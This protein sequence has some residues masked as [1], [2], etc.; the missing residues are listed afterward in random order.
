MTN[1]TS[2][3][4][5]AVNLEKW[6]ELGRR[7][8]QNALGAEGVCS[9]RALRRMLRGAISHTVRIARNIDVYCQRAPEEL[10]AYFPPAFTWL[11]DN[12]Y[13]LRV[14][15]KTVDRTLMGDYRLPKSKDRVLPFVFRLAEALVGQGSAEI[16][17]EIL[18]SFL[19]GVQT[20]C[21]LTEEEINLFPAML[22][23][24]LCCKVAKTAQELRGV[25]AAYLSPKPDTPF[26]AEMLLWRS[27]AKGLA[28][29]PHLMRYACS[30]EPLHGHMER[31]IRGALTLLREVNNA[32]IQAALRK[33]SAL[34]TVLFQ[35]PAHIYGQM[36]DRSRAYYR[37]LVSRLAR[38]GKIPA[39]EMAQKLLRQAQAENTHIGE[40]ILHA[41]EF[42][43]GRKRSAA[44]YLALDIILPVAVSVLLGV[45]FSNFWMTLFA[46][47]PIYEV[48]RALLLYGFNHRL[49][50]NY[51][52]AMALQEGVPPEGQ[53]LAVIALLADSEKQA[54]SHIRLLEEYYLAN[55]T[56]G[57]HVYYGVLADL[58]DAQSAHVPAD[59]S[60]LRAAREEIAELNH[61]WG[62]RF[63]LIY[64]ERRY[65]AGEMAYMAH[66]RKRGAIGALA[67]WVCGQADPEDMPLF[68]GLEEDLLAKTRYL[69]ALDADT[70]PTPD[71]VRLMVGAM[72]HPLNR[73]TV[74]PDGSRVIKGYGI[75]Q[76]RIALELK[77][78][79]ASLFSRIFAGQGGTDP[80]FTAVG[81]V[82]QNLFDDAV[83][84]GK[85]ILDLQVMHTVL[86]GKLPENRILS[87]DLLEGSFLR[88]GYLTDAELIDGFPS[89]VRSYYKRAG[90]WIRGD[91]QLLPYLM[92]QLRN[93]HGNRYPNPL[94]GP[95]KYK[96][97]DNLRRA[98]TP[99][100]VFLCLA[101]Y[102]IFLSPPAAA[103]AVCGLLSLGVPMLL[104]T[105]ERLRNFSN[106]V[107]SRY[108]STIYAG[109][110]GGMLVLFSRFLLLPYEGF[111]ALRAV[112]KALWR[113]TVSKKKL[114]EWVT[115][116]EAERAK[117][118]GLGGEYL[119]MLSQIVLALA[120]AV[121][122]RNALSC[123][124]G[125]LWLLG[126]IYAWWISQKI[127][128]GNDLT[129]REI[130]VLQTHCRAMWRYF[131]DHMTPQDHFLPPDNVQLEPGGMV[132][133]RTSPTNIGLGVLAVLGARY[134]EEISQQEAL[135]R[136]THIAD[137]LER[138]EKWNGHLYNWYHTETL[139]VLPPFVVS[140][141]DSG[142][143]CACLA[144][145]AKVVDRWEEGKALARRL[146]NLAEEADFS[147]LYDGDANL[148]HIA[149]DKEGK[150]VGGH[151]DM[152]ASEARLTGY[153]AIATG[154]V[155]G[156]HWRYLS[157]TMSETNG[158]GGL[159]SWSGSLFEYL[160]PN[161]LL[162]DE[163][164]SLL[165]ETC[166][167]AIYAQRRYG[168]ARHIP[169]GISESCFYA[170]DPA[171]NYQYK[172]HGVYTI[173]LKNG[174]DG[175]L[176]VS[177]YSTFL[178]LEAEPKAALRNLGRLTELG[179]MGPY[180]L[181][182]SADF[183]RERLPRDAPYRVCRT[184]MAHHVGMSICGAVNAISTAKDGQPFF[185]QAFLAD[186]RCRSYRAL[187]GERMPINAINV[188]R[189]RPKPAPKERDGEKPGYRLT[190]VPDPVAPAY[191]LLANHVYSLAMSATGCGKA[192]CKGRLLYQSDLATDGELPG[193][194]VVFRSGNLLC[195]PT[196]FPKDDGQA[197]KR[198]TFSPGLSCFSA[199]SSVLH[200]AENVWVAQEETAENRSVILRNVSK[201][202][203]TGEVCVY[204]QPILGTEAD[205]ESHPDFDRMLLSAEPTE[206]GA[207]ILR[208]N[209]DGTP[210][211]CLAVVCDGKD[212]KITAS[213]LNSIGRREP[214]WA[215][216]YFCNPE[217][218]SFGEVRDC[219]VRLLIP[220]T[221]PAGKEVTI[222]LAL[223]WGSSRD[224]AVACAGRCL[225]NTGRSEF[226][227]KTAD[228]L[229]LSNR[230]VL[231]GLG[232]LPKLLCRYQSSWQGDPKK[233][234]RRHLWRLGISGDLPIVTLACDRFESDDL[235]AKAIFQ[236]VRIHR[237]LSLCGV[238]YDLV[239]LNG[240]GDRYERPTF[241][242]CHW[243][244][245]V[246]QCTE[247]LGKRG[248]IHLP[249][250]LEEQ[251][252]LFGASCMIQ[253]ERD[254]TVARKWS[255]HRTEQPVR[256]IPVALGSGKMP[257]PR[258]WSQPLCNR[259]FGCT[260]TDFGP[261]HLWYRNARL[262]R[263][264]PWESDPLACTNQGERLYLRYQGSRYSVYPSGDG[265]GGTVA[266]AQGATRW[267]K[268]IGDL[269]VKTVAAVAPDK[270]VR[271]LTVTVEGPAEDCY[272]EWMLEPVLGEGANATVRVSQ[273]QKG[274]LRARN[275]FADNFNP[276][277]VAIT[278]WPE[279]NGTLC[280]R[281][282]WT[283]GLWNTH[284]NVS[285]RPI[286]ALRVP[287]D[288][289]GDT[290]RAVLA[291]GADAED[292][293]SVAKS[294]ATPEVAEE[295]RASAADYREKLNSARQLECQDEALC[296]YF[297]NWNA[298][299]IKGARLFA[300]SAYYQ[301]GGAVGFRDQLQDA[302]AFL[303][304]EPD[305]MRNQLLLCAAH[306]YT[307]GDVQHWFHIGFS[308]PMI[309]NGVRTRCSDD[310]LWL[311]L[312]LAHYVE[313]T[314][315]PALAMEQVPYLFSPPL[316]AE[317]GER[318]ENAAVSS[319]VGSMFDH[320]LRA[321]RCFLDRGTG[322]HG[323]PYIGSGD[324]NDG[325]NRLGVEGKG[326]SVWLA[327]FGAMTLTRFAGLARRL[328]QEEVALE[329]EGESL[330][331]CRA[332][333]DCYENGWFLR[334]FDDSGAA[335][336]G[337]NSPAC[338]IDSIAQSFPW[339]AC[340]EPD[341]VLR[342]KMNHGLDEALAKLVDRETG[343][344]L[345]F[346]PPF[347]PSPRVGY[348]GAYPPG[349]RENGGQYTHAAVWLAMACF[350]A[351][352]NNEG[353]ELLKML[354]P[355]NHPKEIYQGEDFV[356]AADVYSAPEHKGLC[357]WSWYT[358]AAAWYRRAVTE[359]MLGIVRRGDQLEITPRLPD[360]MDQCVCTLRR[361][362]TVTRIEINRSANGKTIYLPFAP[363]G[364]AQSF[365]LH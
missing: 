345:L 264:T 87:H 286:M 358:A 138:M 324:W 244:V 296:D 39:H 314:G 121:L 354:L 129:Q 313:T 190:G 221:I 352:R 299:Q 328:G 67:A 185:V 110:R 20:V 84:I 251:A 287:L 284:S 243:A 96:I 330:R 279:A 143:L 249:E 219:G 217:D 213:R 47:W 194:A 19:A 147:L 312:E 74:A 237:L 184:Y 111:C 53:T 282:A 69:I 241:H 6:E 253:P 275:P 56:A 100:G 164:N 83:F 11:T 126:P 283:A 346:T 183:V 95:A 187:L 35:D 172:A 5:T 252:A 353:Y 266:F 351:G 267:E 93:T 171:L 255:S 259:E 33:S 98:L 104:N 135:E 316:G 90:R 257:N 347:R 17:P 37:H 278:A 239:L 61:K 298:W 34:E 337:K 300:R 357:G 118:K 128:V 75:L 310:L 107:T 154:A 200:M 359:G 155:P 25:Q 220:V 355:R 89:S 203:I 117:V 68:Y 8:A 139:A 281:G 170:F 342:K 176:V 15:G 261:T 242:L 291:V 46:I 339:F 186:P 105:I 78:A 363:E 151:Y 226:F 127:P 207:V 173:G 214:R 41:P 331:L 59:E 134:L 153:W 14:T 28:G 212:M 132:A 146:K 222:R 116:A 108:R 224:N 273:P 189:N 240:D 122:G 137:T 288:K 23:C 292:S 344:I 201:E 9:T 307:Q 230:D 32:P 360:C 304:E 70:A 174:L 101:A 338:R 254:V 356:L 27:Y 234:A 364:G 163:E 229:R 120:V 167:Y 236:A 97:G 150:P 285:H 319:E 246:A 131:A 195:S 269:H 166:R 325:M 210:G 326:E 198:F 318:Y 158:F 92:P 72:L 77:G 140:S 144:A 180:G 188:V 16:T 12:V 169:W 295:I 91:V 294:A 225:K 262:F 102:P 119:C 63:A 349:V 274:C 159:V 109:F 178:A 2:Q 130:Q 52:P 206:N 29:E 51:V 263:L 301:N 233:C 76:P 160:M 248:G 293:I 305:C 182:E 156:K 10:R 113:M 65:N 202:R 157:R 250:S 79:N 149:V 22:S 334:A 94:T 168:R 99:V 323:L 297:N 321:I 227:L 115:A 85:G 161:I 260:A 329:L 335:I 290:F 142:N 145:A 62:P 40:Q 112:C 133:H 265:L 44:W 317:E 238:A 235:R 48:T 197:T 3:T 271:V 49:P 258:T 308:D 276:G 18:E 228:R 311:P 272:L 106:K 322:A 50:L 361:G 303:I 247:A 333:A 362:N 64:R 26:G 1:R 24:A 45:L 209:R 336:G 343:I 162:P 136:I 280:D 348:I 270:P 114:L 215:G 13:L 152:L 21:I 192:L 124:I 73:A 86:Q 332:G 218:R 302:S 36:D 204:F 320:G 179:L 43:I 199:E 193:V 289:D 340:Q 205:F 245:R 141:V 175:E 196:L 306:Q 268:Q 216:N 125:G 30:A 38:K 81:D 4:D 88:V 165:Y 42:V 66:E 58:P 7:T 177:P 315:D 54:R 31:D 256:P 123:L 148:F 103:A 191:N 309:R 208:R 80:Y 341:D 57:T 277:E 71:S 365:C 55:R 327:W 350:A 82:Y 223:A 231:D 232:Q 60:I 181:Y 211:G